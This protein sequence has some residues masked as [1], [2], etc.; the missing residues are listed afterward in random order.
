MFQHTLH[1]R[2]GEVDFTER[3]RSEE[4]GKDHQAVWTRVVGRGFDSS[5][6]A[7]QVH[8]TTRT[9]LM[10]I[11][12][13]LGQWTLDD[14]RTHFGVMVGAG[15]ADTNVSSKL[16]DAKSKGAVDGYSVG[17]Y[18]TWFA[19]ASRPTGLY[20]D[21]WLQYGW[22]DNTVRGDG[23]GEE[24]Y[25]SHTLSASVETGYAVDIGHSAKNAWY[26]EPQAQVI[27]SQ[28]KAPK[29]VESNGTEVEVNQ[30]NGVT[31]RLGAR[32]FTRPL[33]ASQK[34]IQPF[35]EMNWWHN[36]GT[37]SMSFNGENQSANLA[38]DIYELKIGAQ[39]ELAQGW[40][41]WGHVGGQQTRDD[42]H[43]AEAQ[44]GIKY[45]W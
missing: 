24:H 5:T 40:T 31:T 15:Q 21:S 28:Y 12:A 16:I 10:Q 3:Q 23:L 34:R 30:G 43:Q 11:G 13:E 7:D 19:D 27:V 44:M 45:S 8:S 36:G 38:S 33:D 14:S 6:G 41:A 26:L 17:I 9:Q 4:G 32:A 42:Q 18:G 2:L 35:V 39:A 25:K 20:V 37:Q 29:H 22:Y 1:D